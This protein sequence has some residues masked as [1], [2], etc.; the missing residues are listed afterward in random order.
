MIARINLSLRTSKTQKKAPVPDWSKLKTDRKLQEKYSVEVKNRYN[1]LMTEDQTPKERYQSFLDANNK[2]SLLRLPKK[3]KKK[4]RK[5]AKDPTVQ[6]LRE[7][8]KQRSEKYHLHATEDN[9]I[10]VQEGKQKFKD[11]YIGCSRAVA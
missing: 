5:V 10:S 7:E 8:L 1:L 6:V 4:G 9:R 3:E 11:A 2:A